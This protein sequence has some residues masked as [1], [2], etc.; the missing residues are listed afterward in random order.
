MMKLSA[1]LAV[2]SFVSIFATSPV[3]AIEIAD[4]FTYA[5][6][7]GFEASHA[8]A[9]DFLNYPV[10]ESVGF[11]NIYLQD[12]TETTGSGTLLNSEWILTAGHCW[13]AN[14][15]NMQFVIGGVTNQVDMSSFV[16]HPLWINAPPPLANEQTDPSQGW[17][18][19]LFK[20]TS[21]ITNSIT[22]PQ[23]YTNSN[24]LGKGSVTL[25]AGYLGTGS[26]PW[27]EQTNNPLLVHAAFNIVD[28]VTS[29]TYTT[30]GTTYG[31]GFIITDFD[32]KANPDQN[33]LHIS[34]NTNGDPWVWDEA[35]NIVVGLDPA[36]TIEGTNSSGAQYMLGTNIVEGGAAPGDS[37]GPTFIQDED[38][39]WKLAAVTSWG[40]NPW[41]ELNNP[42][43]TNVGRRGLYGD[44]NYM[45]RVSEASDWIYSVIPEPS[46]W[47]LLIISGLGLG[48]IRLRQ[49]K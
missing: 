37:G 25:G 2:F 6:M 11:F 17:D 7:S 13:G 26:T 44:V 4:D 24:E 23:L 20:L 40:N 18:L 3:C 43:D 42:G 16:I 38:G 22:Y 15:T 41:D 27:A 36:G 35:T 45:V 1:V 30:N 5:G 34:Y 19:A 31:G 28:R 12:E 33:T 21:P 9:T 47:A 32:S 29:Q 48:L 14:V 39:T 49:R 8:L 46:T 10:F